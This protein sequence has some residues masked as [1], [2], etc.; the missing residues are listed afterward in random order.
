MIQTMGDYGLT[1]NNL[2]PEQEQLWYNEA[3]RA[4]PGLVGT[5]FDRNIYNRIN[6][7]LQAYRSRSR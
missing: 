5:L 1:V 3:G 2:T 6:A 7:L 4:M